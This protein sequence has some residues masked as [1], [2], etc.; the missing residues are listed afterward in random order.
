MANKL[1]SELKEN[2]KLL[3]AVIQ[4]MFQNVMRLDAE[5]RELKAKAESKDITDKTALQFISTHRVNSSEEKCQSKMEIIAKEV[6]IVKKV[7]IS[8]QP[9]DQAEQHDDL[10]CDMCEYMCK[11]K[12]HNKKHEYQAQPK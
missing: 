1:V 4:N 12:K 7:I 2:V 10:K 5:I 9:T 6:D 8:K 11:K 3:D